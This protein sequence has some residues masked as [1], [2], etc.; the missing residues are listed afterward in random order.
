MESSS[1]TASGQPSGKY[2]VG[3]SIGALGV[4]YG[5]IGTSPLYA[6]RE[7]FSG[8]EGLAVTPA[9]IE[10]VLSLICW[11]LILVISIKYLVFILRADNNGEGGILAL[12]ALVT[13]MRASAAG[14]RAILIALGLFGAA[15]LY[16]DGM[17]TPAISVL[18]AVEG[19]GVAT[20]LFE[21]YII[22]L[23][24]LIL[25]GLFFFQ[26]RGTGGL[27]AV[28]GPL[29]LIWFIVLGVLGAMNIFHGPEVLL[30]VNPWS[31]VVFFAQNGIH[32]F[33]VLGSV[34]LVV[35]GG[36]ALY[37]DMGHFGPKPIK[38]AWFSIALISLLLNYFGQGALLIRNPAAAENPFYHM[39]P[40]WALYPLVG[41][42]TI[43]TVIA[44]QAVISGAFSLT[45]QAVQLGYSPRLDIQ[46]TSQTERGQ[47]YLPFV[48][49]V[50]MICCIGL[51]LGF[52]SSSNL[53][54]AYGIA[55]T[56]TMGITTLLF[57]VVARYN[58]QWSLWRAVLLC[59]LFMVFD[60]S[61]FGANIVK[62]E[63]GGWFPLLVAGIIFALMSTWKWGRA[64]LGR[65]LMAGT[66]PVK[67]FIDNVLAHP[68]LRVPG[69]AVFMSGNPRGTP[70]ALLHNLKHNHV[71]HE[72]VILVSVET[73]E[74]PHVS[75]DERV[76]VERLSEGVYRMII[77]YGFMEDP[78]VPKA[79]QKV[80]LDGWRYNPMK[81][82]FFLGRE[83][84]LAKE[85]AA[86]WGIRE[87][88]FVFMS[89]NSRNATD[90]FG[91]PPNR[92]VELGMQVQL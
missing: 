40:S 60:L 4:V 63:N 23:T 47:I 52:R 13:P 66:I 18:S 82:T 7:C 11:S 19:L 16:G 38:L 55:V 41:I 76:S 27:G 6:L 46:H 10:G 51:V 73:A 2:L 34:F 48:N 70:S 84:L 26:Q 35:T 86:M 14:G 37:A 85:T 15:L 12:T 20:P 67:D 9:N 83:T 90:F 29:T 57:F 91:L 77:H 36:E 78:N 50:L 87:Q 71:L 44:S 42:A 24:I 59:G 1:K 88:L 89:R 61:F 58:W 25:L 3:L 30:A 65:R 64:I 92:V 43:A 72:L 33:L 31:A 49:K 53:A 39:A 28:F 69:A 45:M 68:P 8:A 74:V 54:S 21:P 80:N 62:I 5:D 17:I 22:P 79:L 81:T 32:G 56:T 75:E